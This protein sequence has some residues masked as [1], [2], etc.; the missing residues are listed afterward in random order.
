METICLKCLRKGQR[1]RYQS[2]GELA[3]DL[4]RWLNGEPIKARRVGRL[5]KSWLWCKRR[6]V[7]AGLLATVVFIQAVGK[8]FSGF[9]G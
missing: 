4:Q 1:S 7:V 8:G 2:A 5:E 9:H 6:P 3:E